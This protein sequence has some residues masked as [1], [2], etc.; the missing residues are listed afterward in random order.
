MNPIM[1]KKHLELQSG[2][3]TRQLS[4]AWQ[5]SVQRELQPIPLK[6]GRKQCLRVCW[7]LSGSCLGPV[8]VKGLTLL[9][10]RLS[11]EET[12]SHSWTLPWSRTLRQGGPVPGC[13]VRFLPLKKVQRLGWHDACGLS[14]KW[15]RGIA[16]PYFAWHK[17]QSLPVCN[18]WW[19]TAFVYQ[20]YPLIC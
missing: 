7:E 17:D 18:G 11:R 20:F 4:A 8:T 3:A 2:W 19:K 1:R 13:F 14:Y 9:L 5:N 10:P 16:W 12:H 6:W 15:W